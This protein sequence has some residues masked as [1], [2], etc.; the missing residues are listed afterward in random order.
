MTDFEPFITN[1][2]RKLLL[3][4]EKLIDTGNAGRYNVLQDAATLADQ[5][6]GEVAIDVAKWLGFLAFD[7][8]SDLAF[9]QPFGFV[10]AGADTNDGIRILHERGEWS[11]TVGTMPWIKRALQSWQTSSDA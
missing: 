8:I 1:A 5:S 11:A 6:K 3:Q 2:I 10:D 9:S 4:F 7:I